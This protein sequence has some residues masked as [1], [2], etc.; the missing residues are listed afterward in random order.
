M[1]TIVIITVVAKQNTLEGFGN[2]RESLGQYYSNQ[3]NDTLQNYNQS[4]YAICSYSNLLSI[5]RTTT[6][7]LRFTLTSC[8][9]ALMSVIN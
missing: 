5:I 4:S 2:T 1:V 9:P 7:A 6:P 3:S 8:V